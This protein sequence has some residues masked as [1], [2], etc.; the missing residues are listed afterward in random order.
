MLSKIDSRGAVRAAVGTDVLQF[1]KQCCA[2]ARNIAY[3]QEY[4][5]GPWWKNIQDGNAKAIRNFSTCEEAILYAQNGGNSGFDHRACDMRSIVDFKIAELEHLFPGFSFE[6]FANLQESAYSDKSTLVQRNGAW[7]SNAFLNHVG[8]HLRCTHCLDAGSNLK[9]VIE[10]GAGYGGLARVFKIM[11]PDV[12]Y[13]IVDLPESLFFAHIFLSTNFPDAKILYLQQ[14]NADLDADQFDFVLV[15]VQ[16]YRAL[17]GEEYDLCINTASLQEMPDATVDFW[18]DFIQRVIDAKML[19]SF[20]YFLND[21]KQYLETSSVQANLICPKLDPFWKLRYFKINPK[22]L[23]VDLS[24]RNWLEVCVERLPLQIRD[25]NNSRS[26]AAD[27]FKMAGFHPRGSNEW[28]GYMWMSMWCA[29]ELEGLKNEM[30]K[31]IAVFESGL[32]A[33]NNLVPALDCRLSGRVLHVYR[34]VKQV[35]KYCIKKFVNACWKKIYPSVPYEEYHCGEYHY[36]QLK[37]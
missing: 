31:G 30:L 37:G 6:K 18:A 7:Y 36:Y 25:V 22:V 1:A 14:D 19:Y 21:K 10:I 27:L 12:S 15:P 5:V 26:Y 35:M 34:F 4:A 23:T 33:S 2:K 20:N 29:P 11:N 24:E 17:K 16:Y 9:R 13:T 3:P 8:Y 28:F 32:G